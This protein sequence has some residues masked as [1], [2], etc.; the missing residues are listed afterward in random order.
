MSDIAISA[1]SIDQKLSN[2]YG[3]RPWIEERI[4]GHRLWDSQSAWLLFLEFLVVAEARLR[5]DSLLEPGGVQHRQSYRPYQRMHLRNILFNEDQLVRIADEISD[6]NTAWDRWVGWM[7]GN[8]RAAEGFSYLRTRF[9]NFHVFAQLIG[10]LRS[11]VVDSDTGR[12]WTSRFVFPFGPNSLYEDVAIKAVGGGTERQYI[13][14]GR[15]GELLYL[16]LSRSSSAAELRPYLAKYLSRGDRWDRWDRLIGQLQPEPHPEAERHLGYLPYTSHP[17]F[18]RLGEDWLAIFRLEVPGFDGVPHLVT[19]SALHIML[20][21]LSVAVER[22]SDSASVPIICEVV[23]PRKTLVREL[24]IGSYLRNNAL[25]LQAADHR[26]SEIES[27]DEWIEASSGPGAFEQCLEILEREACWGREREYEGPHTPEA[28]I[29][30]FRATVS[31]RHRQHVGNVH[32]TY[33]REAGLVSKRG[34]NRLRYAPTDELLKTLLFA[35]VAQRLELGEFLAI[36][37]ERYGMV[38]GDQEADR[39]IGKGEYDKKAF[40]ANARRLEQ[41]LSSLGLLRRLSDGCAY[42]ENPHRKAKE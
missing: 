8:A 33:G 26:V 13:N 15:T 1:V 30:D 16:M 42:V 21:Q 29:E 35:N 11:S 4:W 19:L 31:K 5:A 20:Y 6:S 40:Q 2:A 9:P 38:F 25:S 12:R 27:S 28:L 7:D 14:F 34:T 32:R 36:L 18:D 10:M 22:V 41:R 17:S 23:A 39:I 3:T 24:S 37:Y